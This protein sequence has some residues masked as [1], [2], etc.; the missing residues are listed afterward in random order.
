MSD[1]EGLTNALR[2]QRQIDEDG[3]ERGVSRQA[4]DEAITELTRLDRALRTANETIESLSDSECDKVMAMTDEQVR[5]LSAVTGSSADIDALK[6]KVAVTK[7]MLRFERARAERAEA[8]L[9]EKDKSIEAGGIAHRLLAE[10]LDTTFNDLQTSKADL[11]AA[12]EAL[13]EKNERIVQLHGAASV[14]DWQQVQLNGGP[15]CFHIEDGRF[16]LRAQWWEGHKYFHAAVTLADAI[17]WMQTGKW[18][19]LNAARKGP[20]KP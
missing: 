11:A 18:T 5:A 7:A 8:A 19:A 1:I 6:G 2:Q 3:T 17:L 4:V 14:A 9:R 15:P 16:C 13:S 20:A 10:E 12:R